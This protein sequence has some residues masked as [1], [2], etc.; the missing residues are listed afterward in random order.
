MHLG[1]QWKALTDSEREKHMLGGA[2]NQAPAFAPASASFPAPAPVIQQSSGQLSCAEADR[3]WH[4]NNAACSMQH[5]AALATASSFS[6]AEV[7]SGVDLVDFAELVELQ[8]DEAAAALASHAVELTHAEL[9]ST[10]SVP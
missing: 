9:V 2:S 8:D 6:A 1:Q 10:E 5:A 3:Q 7:D 4:A